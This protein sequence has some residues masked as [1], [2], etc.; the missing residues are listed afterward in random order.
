MHSSNRGGSY[1]NPSA[2]DQTNRAEHVTGTKLFCYT[3]CSEVT[4]SMVREGVGMP[5]KRKAVTT[6]NTHR[7]MKFHNNPPHVKTPPA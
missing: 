7:S 4:C 1:G 3:S 2:D 6:C 5:I